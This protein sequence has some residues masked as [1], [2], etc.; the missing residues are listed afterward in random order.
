M[1]RFS[2]KFTIIISIISF[3]GCNS[4]T[5]HNSP[6]YQNPNQV[7]NGIYQS[8][9]C[10]GDSLNV[11]SNLNLDESL[12][13]IWGYYD[14][15][16]K[17]DYA[18]VGYSSNGQGIYVIDISHPQNPAVVSKIQNVSGFDIK[19][20]KNYIY[21]VHGHDQSNGDIIDISNPQNPQIAGSFTHGH[22]IFI[23]NKG[24]LYVAKPGIKIFN[25]N[26]NP[27]DPLLVW[28]K[29]TNFGHDIAVI[30]DTLYDFHGDGGTNI[31][32]IQNVKD[33]ILLTH[34]STEQV[35]YSHS[36]WISNKKSILYITNER[37]NFGEEADI[38]AWDINNI[39]SLKM[40]DSFSSPSATAHNIYTVCN[41]A[42][43]SYYLDGVKLFDLSS[44]SNMK[45]LDEYD[46]S[47]N[48]QGK[49][50]F[51]G[52]WGA[53]PYTKSGNILISDTNNGLFIF[54]RNNQGF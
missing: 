12:T 42:I 9:Q 34:I 29:K 46:T 53:F 44:P 14:K 48:R 33:P 38:T 49:H 16:T 27:T 50:K 40:T 32:N 17:K 35:S 1:F 15:A 11:V 6:N 54:K 26:N 45:L 5:N 36:G 4:S 19:I 30:N 52:A 37:A 18:I 47:P 2:N 20:W 3:L 24:Y 7:Y 21:S 31:Y 23:T 43:V 8:P 22:N 28:T 41:K 25:L 51:S 39:D 10:L 13:D